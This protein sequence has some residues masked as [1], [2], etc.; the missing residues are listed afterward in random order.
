M[1]HC[2]SCTLGEF[3]SVYKYQYLHLNSNPNWAW[4]KSDGRKAENA[5]TDSIMNGQSQLLII[6]KI[7][8]VC[9]C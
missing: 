6:N 5:S 8:T 1:S 7:D 4:S 2:D 9:S 3:T